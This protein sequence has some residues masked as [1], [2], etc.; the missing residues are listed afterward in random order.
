MSAFGG[1]PATVARRRRRSTGLPGIQVVTPHT[2]AAAKPLIRE[3]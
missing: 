3:C 2:V 1:P